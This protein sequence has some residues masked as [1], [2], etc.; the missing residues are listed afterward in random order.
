M[1]TRHKAE[2]IKAYPNVMQNPKNPTPQSCPQR[3]GLYIGKK[4][5]MDRPGRTITPAC[6]QSLTAKAS[7]GLEKMPRWVQVILQ[8]S[9]AHQSQQQITWHCDIWMA[10]SQGL[11]WWG[12]QSSRHIRCTCIILRLKSTSYKRWSVGWALTGTQPCNLW[13]QGQLWIYCSGCARVRKLM[14]R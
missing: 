14:G 6:V 4:P 13:L 8:V 12:A 5:V 3:N 9:Y 10:Q 11:V 2:Q 1:E 7:Q